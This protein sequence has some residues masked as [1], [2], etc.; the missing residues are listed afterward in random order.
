MLENMRQAASDSNSAAGMITPR[1][2]RKARLASLG[3][4]L[5]AAMVATLIVPQTGH[6]QS[7]GDQVMLPSD[8]F[9]A[10]DGDGLRVAPTLLMEPE[11]SVTGEYDN[12]VYN[13]PFDEIED[14]VAVIRPAV[15]F[16]TD[17]PRH[18]VELHGD[19]QIRRYADTTDENSEQFQVYGITRLDLGSRI[20]FRT[21]LGVAERIERRGTTGDAFFTD[22]PVEFTEY[23][24]GAEVERGGGVFE[25][26]GNANIRRTDYSQANVDG[27]PQSLDFR[28]A[29]IVSGGVTTRYQIGTGTRATVRVGL[30]D[31]KYLVDTG[32]PRDSW[33]YNALAGIQYEVSALVDVEVAAGF[34]HQEFE[35]PTIDSVNGIDY[36]V[37]IDWTPSPQYLVTVEGSRNIIASPLN[38]APIIIRSN[39]GLT[40]QAAATNRLL[41]DAAITYT[42][43]DYSG[44]NRADQFYFAGVGANY[45]LIENVSLRALAGWRQRAS[46][47]TSAEHNGIAVGLGLSLVI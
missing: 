35:D 12:N 26:A 27:V 44:T 14:F 24:A 38:D 1:G 30:N 41:F 17:L 9:D 11:L 32:T 43:E 33:G 47:V 46:D 6:A 25:I 2:A 28:D 3:L 18:A 16:R 36:L 10:P 20:A 23:N 37:S 7:L 34:V 45:V 15:T 31:V 29:R 39:L 13:Q 19:A 5:A 4:P 42:Q 8:I 21:N 22:A 40:A